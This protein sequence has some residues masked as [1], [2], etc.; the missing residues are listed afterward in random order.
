MLVNHAASLV[1]AVSVFT[2]PEAHEVIYGPDD[3]G[4]HTVNELAEVRP[5]AVNE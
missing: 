1:S 5:I 2:L 4:R 3:T